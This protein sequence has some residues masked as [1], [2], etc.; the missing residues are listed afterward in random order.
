MGYFLECHSSRDFNFLNQLFIVSADN[1]INM[2]YSVLPD[3]A[4]FLNK[5]TPHIVAA[6]LLSIVVEIILRYA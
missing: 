5:L 4:P 1:S 6:R 2:N 3:P